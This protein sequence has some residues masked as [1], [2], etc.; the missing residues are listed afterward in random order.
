MGCL[1]LLKEGTSLLPF[2]LEGS[3]E[4]GFGIDGDGCTDC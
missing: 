2:C 3:L 1:C 4:S